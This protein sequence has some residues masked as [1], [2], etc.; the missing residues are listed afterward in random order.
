MQTEP[1][2]GAEPVQQINV[3]EAKA[4]PDPIAAAKDFLALRQQTTER[5]IKHRGELKQ[6]LAEANE[7]L[8]KLSPKWGSPRATPAEPPV[9]RERKRKEA[10]PPTT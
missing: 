4:D 2:P 1:Q 3:A 7:A 5:L 8:R 6:R 10:T 9:K